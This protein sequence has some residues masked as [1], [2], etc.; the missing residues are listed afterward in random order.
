[1]LTFLRIV[2]ENLIGC[3]FP[4]KGED[5]GSRGTLRCVESRHGKRKESPGKGQIPQDR[6]AGMN[7][8]KANNTHSDQWAP[9][10]SLP[11]A[12]AVALDIKTTGSLPPAGYKRHQTWGSA[13]PARG[14]WRDASSTGHDGFNWAQRSLCDGKKFNSLKGCKDL[15]FVHI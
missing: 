13:K 9:P 5:K 11:T 12:R 2:T 14:G 10:K 4:L 7:L 6:M 8:N 15:K 3:I 1:M